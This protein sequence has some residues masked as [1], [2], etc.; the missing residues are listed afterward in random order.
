MQSPLG[1][2]SFPPCAQV[3]AL[4]KHLAA[5]L[6]SA[7][8]YLASV[9]ASERQQQH[10]AEDGRPATP[11]PQEQQRRQARVEA[12]PVDTVRHGQLVSGYYHPSNHGIIP[13]FI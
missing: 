7:E 3:P 8:E 4:R 9:D 12:H 13:L 5:T 1:L 2:K 10:A 6:M 11:T